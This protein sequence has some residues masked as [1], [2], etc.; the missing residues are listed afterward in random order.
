MLNL[1]PIEALPVP[2]SDIEARI[3]HLH[4][5]YAI[6]LLSDPACKD[7]FWYYLLFT[8]WPTTI[9]ALDPSEV[10]YNR[11]YWFCRVSALHRSA[12]GPDAG[13]DQQAPSYSTMPRC[14]WIGQLSRKLRLGLVWVCK[15]KLPALQTI[16]PPHSS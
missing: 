14:P 2:P 10:F 13:F 3:K 16:P 9:G 1:V 6:G 8:H 12:H 5:H 11:Y 4:A 7:A 15:T